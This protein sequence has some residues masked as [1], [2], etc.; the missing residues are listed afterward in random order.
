MT[1]S[2][3]SEKSSFTSLLPQGSSLD[4]LLGCG[5]QVYDYWSAY[6]TAQDSVEIDGTV[7]PDSLVFA[8]IDDLITSKMDSGDIGMCVPIFVV[9]L[10]ELSNVWF[11]MCNCLFGCQSSCFMAFN[12]LNIC[13]LM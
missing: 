7:V 8:R 6:A 4:N 12:H 13:L 10:N 5:V 9:I 1:L 3:R 2:T 11:V